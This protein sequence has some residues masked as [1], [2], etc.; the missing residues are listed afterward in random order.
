LFNTLLY[1]GVNMAHC[2]ASQCDPTATMIPYSL[3]I[4]PHMPCQSQSVTV[5]S[6]QAVAWCT[7]WYH[8]LAGLLIDPTPSVEMH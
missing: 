8:P 2:S 3:S 5:P 4:L 7:R 6:T 1:V